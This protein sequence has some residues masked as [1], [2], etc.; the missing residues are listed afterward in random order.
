MFYCWV[1]C[2]EPGS[3]QSYINLRYDAGVMSRV[4]CHEA[5]R[6]AVTEMVTVSRRRGY[7]GDHGVLSRDGR[8]CRWMLEAGRCDTMNPPPAPLLLSS[9]SDGVVPGTW[10]LRYY[11]SR[12]H[13]GNWTDHPLNKIYLSVKIMAANVW[14]VV[15]FQK[16]SWNGH[17]VLEHGRLALHATILHTNFF[18][19]YLIFGFQRSLLERPICEN[20]SRIASEKCGAKQ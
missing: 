19:V 18:V 2:P 16:T 17:L 9:L 20:I 12:S 10:K 15:W 6:D 8:S 13:G 14:L 5:A 3:G 1:H 4:T 11:R 7:W